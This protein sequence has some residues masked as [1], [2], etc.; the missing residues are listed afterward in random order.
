VDSTLVVAII[1]L[2]FGLP[3]GMICAYLMAPRRGRLLQ[4]LGSLAGAAGLGLAVYAYATTISVDLLSY[5]IGAFL[6]IAT[7]AV[8]GDL[9]VNFL[10]S[11]GGRRSRS[12]QVGI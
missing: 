10:L 9:V 2:I 8:I 4:F 1:A 12:A 11:L 5:G 7:G 6:A 3:T